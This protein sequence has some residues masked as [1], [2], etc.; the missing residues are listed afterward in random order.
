[1]EVGKD[2]DKQTVGQSK[3]LSLI[4]FIMKSIPSEGI[5]GTTNDL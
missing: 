4:R 5:E 2:L 3:Q 1:M